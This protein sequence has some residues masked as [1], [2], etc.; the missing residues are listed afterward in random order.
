[1]AFFKRI[2]VGSPLLGS[3][4]LGLLP[5]PSDLSRQTKRSGN[6]LSVKWSVSLGTVDSTPFSEVYITS[7]KTVLLHGFNVI[8]ARGYAMEGAQ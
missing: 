7:L 2:H 6:D 3:L 4:F 1:T 8:S 5:V